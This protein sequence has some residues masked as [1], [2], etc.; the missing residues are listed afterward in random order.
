MSSNINDFANETKSLEQK[1]EKVIW[2]FERDIQL[3]KKE[4]QHLKRM[5]LIV[6]EQSNENKKE[7]ETLRRTYG[8]NNL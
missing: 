2:L 7:I 8:T 6:Y 3:L 1:I 4:N 5:L